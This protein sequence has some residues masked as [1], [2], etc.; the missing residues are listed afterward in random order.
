MIK[1]AMLALVLGLVAIPTFAQYYEFDPD[2]PDVELLIRQEAEF[3]RKI[4]N[5]GTAVRS[6][7]DGSRIRIPGYVV[8]VGFDGLM[9]REFLLVP[10]AGACIHTPPPPPSQ[11][12]HVDAEQGFEIA[13]LYTPVWVS[14]ELTAELTRHAADMSDGTSSFDVGYRIVDGSVEIY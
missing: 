5:Q 11:I 6:D 1:K 9:I 8:P 2:D 7:L 3:R 4:S 10:Y 12:I 14:G 13:D